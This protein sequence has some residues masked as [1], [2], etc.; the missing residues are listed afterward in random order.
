MIVVEMMKK[1]YKVF[2]SFRFPGDN[3]VVVA[4]E[5]KPGTKRINKVII[6]ANAGD[7]E[8]ITFLGKDNYFYN[9]IELF[10]FKEKT[11]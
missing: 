7:E 10:K 8:T 5:H 3:A 2:K 1:D 9:V 4:I 6:K 11:E